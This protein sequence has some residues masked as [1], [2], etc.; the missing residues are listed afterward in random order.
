M[1]V[2]DV[3]KKDTFDHLPS[4]AKDVAEYTEGKTP[5]VIVANKIDCESE[6]E[7]SRGN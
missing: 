3:T 6:W 2:Y 4:W 7:V 5:V 1:L